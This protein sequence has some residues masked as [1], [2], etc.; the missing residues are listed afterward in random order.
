M[1]LLSTLVL[2]EEVVIVPKFLMFNLVPDALFGK[3]WI[4]T[5]IPLILPSWFGGGAFAVFLIRQFLLQIPRDLDEAARID[6]ANSLQILLSIL[7]PLAKPVLA[8]VGIF[9]FLGHWTDFW[10][11]L[12]YI[13]S[14]DRFP[15]SVG[16]R[17]F[18]QLPQDPT[19]PRDHLLMAASLLMMLPCL[20]LFFT[21]QRAFVQG[22]VMS[23]IKG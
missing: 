15:L 22:I 19:E 3:T 6:G 13:N 4:D 2:P 20:V 17:W 16:L 10:H 18:Q 11:P 23:G 9:V 5:W 7:L 14:T 12:I 1:V 8:T 21:M